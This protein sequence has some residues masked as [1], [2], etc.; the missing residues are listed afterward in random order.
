MRIIIAVSLS[1][2]LLFLA[3]CGPYTKLTPIEKSRLEDQFETM[4]KSRKQMQ[5]NA[6]YLVQVKLNTSEVKRK[7]KLEIYVTSDSISFYSPGFLGKGT[8]KGII[9]GDSLKFYLPS[10]NVYYLGPWHELTDPDLSRWRDVFVLMRRIFKGDLMPDDPGRPK[11][12]QYKADPEQGY[13]RIKGQTRVWDYVFLF[14]GFDFK[15]AVYNWADAMLVMNH[16]IRSLSDDFPYFKYDIANLFYT[17]EIERRSHPDQEKFKSEIRLEFIEQ[18][19]NLDIPL[20]KF[21]LK[22]PQSAEEIEELI[23]E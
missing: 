15:Y 12:R 20:E 2:I 8:F 6:A 23:I 3:S 10:D 4:L 9:F 13:D 21:E 5:K 17:N 22:I 18:F 19:Y 1:L 14:K 16:K 7:F 11:P